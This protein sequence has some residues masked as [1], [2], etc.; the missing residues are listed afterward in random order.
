MGFLPVSLIDA[1]QGDSAGVARLDQAIGA[2][3]RR[4]GRGVRAQAQ[5]GGI[6]LAD[7]AADLHLAGGAVALARLQR[8]RKSII[9]PQVL[10]VA[11]QQIGHVHHGIV[12]IKPGSRLGGEAGRLANLRLGPVL[13]H[14]VTLGAQ[15]GNLLLQRSALDIEG[16]AVAIGRVEF[17]PAR[18]GFGNLLIDLAHLVQIGQRARRQQVGIDFLGNVFNLAVGAFLLCAGSYVFRSDFYPRLGRAT[19]PAGDSLA[20][21]LSLQVG[22]GV[23]LRRR[24]QVGH[25][26]AGAGAAELDRRA[27]AE[28]VRG[29]QRVIVHRQASGAQGVA[30]LAVE[31]LHHL[32]RARGI[33]ALGQQF[34]AAHALRPRRLGLRDDVQPRVSDEL[35]QA[36]R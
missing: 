20:L 13:R 24:Q 8:G 33:G 32:R 1:F 28:V 34:L 6:E 22:I 25:G 36:G 11:G 18:F 30:V 27:R 15:V 7:D 16:R 29:V 31:R 17:L 10:V 14:V 2:D 21:G 9:A 19:I 3:D 26:C 5:P 4:A 35:V 12:A 23:H